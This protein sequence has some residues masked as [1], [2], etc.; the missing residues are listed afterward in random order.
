M[1]GGQGRIGLLLREGLQAHC[2]ER[3]DGLVARKFV[4]YVIRTRGDAVMQYLMDGMRYLAS[5]GVLHMP[6]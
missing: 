6:P 1:R 2:E 5:S 3:R 4:W